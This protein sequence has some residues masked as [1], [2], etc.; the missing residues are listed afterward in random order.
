M[1][2]R[3]GWETIMDKDKALQIAVEFNDISYWGA[4]AQRDAD[5]L[6]VLPLLEGVR[7]LVGEAENTESADWVRIKSHTFA[8]LKGCLADLC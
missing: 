6:R 7:V 8:F 1:A 5:W 4:V 2:I 3:E